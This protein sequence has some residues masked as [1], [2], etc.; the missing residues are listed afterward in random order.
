MTPDKKQ[1]QICSGE[2]CSDSGPTKIPTSD[3]ELVI[4][5]HKTNEGKVCGEQDSCLNKEQKQAFPLLP[6]AKIL[7]AAGRERKHCRRD[8]QDDGGQDLMQA[9]DRR[10]FSC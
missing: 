2:S 10:V 6:L 5:N 1:K 3:H 9:G 7:R 8:S 4:Q